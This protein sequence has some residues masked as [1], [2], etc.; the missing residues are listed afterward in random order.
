M[1]ERSAKSLAL[2]IMQPLLK[3]LLRV[4][5]IQIKVSFLKTQLIQKLKQKRL[6]ELKE[7]LIRGIKEI[8][9]TLIESLMRLRLALILEPC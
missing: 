4:L 7:Q 9:G 8:A 2:K 6:L 1:L 5:K 3:F